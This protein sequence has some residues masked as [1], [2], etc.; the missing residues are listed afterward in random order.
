[1]RVVV[2]GGRFV[3]RGRGFESLSSFAVDGL[4]VV[5]GAEVLVED[6]AVATVEGLLAAV[7]V[8]EVVDLEPIQ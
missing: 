6:G 3:V 4:G 2:G 8:A 5:A 7:G 1:M